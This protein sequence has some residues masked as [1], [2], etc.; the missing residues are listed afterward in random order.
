MARNLTKDDRRFE[1]Y[2]KIT[3]KCRHCGH[4]V[5]IH[6]YMEKVIYTHCGYWVFRTPKDEFMFRVGNFLKSG[7]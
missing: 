1:E 4:I 3:Y 2:S 6:G 5:T 7:D